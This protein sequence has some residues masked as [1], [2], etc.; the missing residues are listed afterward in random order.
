MNLD[1]P[2]RSA[3]Q[4]PEQYLSLKPNNKEQRAAFKNQLDILLTKKFDPQQ[5]RPF[6]NHYP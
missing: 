6:P 4:H 2:F 1:Q 5:P 3:I